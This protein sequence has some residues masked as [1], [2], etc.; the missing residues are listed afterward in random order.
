MEGQGNRVFAEPVALCPQGNPSGC[1]MDGALWI[2][3]KEEWMKTIIVS[4][5]FGRSSALERLCAA[6]Q[7]EA[8]IVDPYEAVVMNFENEKQA[9]IHFSRTV[10]FDGYVHILKECVR[11]QETEVF[12]IGFSVGAAAIW[13]MSANATVPNVKKAMCYYGSQIRNHLD[14]VPAFPVGLV[15][16][17][18]EKHFS[19][20]E[21]MAKLSGKENISLRQVPYLHGFMNELSVNYDRQGYMQEIQ[22]LCKR[23]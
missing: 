5:I 3:F 19:V 9:Y 16:P 13:A 7:S 1:P 22:T 20:E 8:I 10:G 15:F 12:L 6:L 2:Q 17:A 18:M 23:P 21:V 11:A 4:D 14:S